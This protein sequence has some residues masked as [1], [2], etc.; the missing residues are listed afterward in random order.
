MRMSSLLQL[1]MLGGLVLLAPLS[2]GQIHAQDTAPATPK[3]AAGQSDEKLPTPQEVIDRYIKVTGGAD[4]YKKHKSQTSRGFF[5]MPTMGLKGPMVMYQAVPNNL[6]VSIEMPGIGT[7]EQG[8]NGT[9]GWSLDPMRGPTLM[10]GP[11]LEQAK[12]EAEFFGSLDMLKFFDSAKTSGTTDFNGTKCYQLVLTAPDGVT[13]AFYSVESGL[14]M[15][16]KSVAATPLGDVP[17]VTTM[18]EYKD[19]GGIKIPTLTKIEVM[20]QQQQIVLDSVTY[21]DVDPKVF[22]LPAKIEPLVKAKEAGKDGATEPKKSP[23]AAGNGKP[24]S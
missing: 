23:P 13:N 3:A 6:Y 9:V 20:G 21:D 24:G 8:F 16:M 10:E 7:M 4:A 18:S 19:F 11:Q 12:R 17:S 22:V 15:G 14:A 2:A 1:T 5:E